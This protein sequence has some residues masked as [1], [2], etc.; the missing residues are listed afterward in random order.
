MAYLYNISLAYLSQLEHILDLYT[1]TILD[2]SKLS[3]FNSTWVRQDLQVIFFIS[4]SILTR[5]STQ[6]WI[7]I[8]MPCSICQN[9]LCSMST[10]EGQFS[11]VLVSLCLIRPNQLR[12][13]ST[14][15][16]LVVTDPQVPSQL[17]LSRNRNQFWTT[18]DSQ[19]MNQ[20]ASKHILK[21]W[22]P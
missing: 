19:S 4:K 13:I 8:I 17:V 18:I 9:Y 7:T 21:H 6:F 20:R 16:G 2:L 5:N 15:E 3:A 22:F 10:W 1:P 12:S 14:L 11:Q